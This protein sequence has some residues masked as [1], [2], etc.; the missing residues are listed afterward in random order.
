MKFYKKLLLIFSFILFAYILLRLLKKI[1][2]IE[3][4]EDTNTEAAANE[5][6]QYAVMPST[7][8]NPVNIF[9]LKN[10]NANQSIKSNGLLK[11]SSFVTGLPVSQYCV[12]SSYN[13][14][15]SGKYVSKEMLVNVIKKGCR[16]LDFEV[17]YGS[18]GIPYVAET[19]DP[20]YTIISTTNKV[21]LDDILNTAV[22]HSFSLSAPNIS[23]PLFIHL[24]IKSN[25]KSVYK[26]VA[27]SVDFA[28]VN[29]LYTGLFD[30]KTTL[31]AIMGKV[32][33]IIDKTI[34]RDYKNFSVCTLNEGNCYELTTYTNLESGSS[35]MKIQGHADLLSQTTNPPRILDD[36]ISDVTQIQISLPDVP[37]NQA[38][39]PIITPYVLKYGCQ[40]VGYRFY[41]PDQNL[42]DYEKFFNHFGFA[43]VPMASAI[44]YFK[45]KDNE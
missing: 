18:D 23:D 38:P 21:P 27:K 19:T 1:F 45:K 43:F 31:D 14:A 20:A 16:F 42:T 3:N 28:L 40:F 17:V 8:S 39:N 34:N 44:E 12:K 30:E 37:S 9:S 22:T 32:I 35:F 11:N 13:S 15:I 10:G 33:L 24:R 6:K 29:R 41:L 4:F 26:A 7:Q 5:A 36:N 2:R 25:E